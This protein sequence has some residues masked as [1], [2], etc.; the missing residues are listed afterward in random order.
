MKGRE[1]YLLVLKAGHLIGLMGLRLGDVA[2]EVENI[3]I[4]ID[5]AI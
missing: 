1:G 2:D 4:A 5:A 3:L